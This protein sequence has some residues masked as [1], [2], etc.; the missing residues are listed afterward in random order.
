MKLTSP[1]FA[2]SEPIPQQFTADG[3]DVSPVLN[4]QG[5][6]AGV[7]SFALICDDPDAPAGT[8]V[9][10]LIYRIPPEATGLQAEA[11]RAG[12]LAN[13]ARQGVSGSGRIGYE[14]PAPPAGPVHHYSFRIYA[15]DTMPDLKPGA[16]KEQLLAA[17]EGHILGQG[18]LTGLYKR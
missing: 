1:F 8:W 4:W 10:W 17:M 12:T 18:E 9:H 16:T 5:A 13:G 2:T 3:A 15:L 6:P 7:K 11:P 14:G